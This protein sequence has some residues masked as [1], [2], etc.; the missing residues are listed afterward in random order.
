LA[1][2]PWDELVEPLA[3]KKTPTYLEFNVLEFAVERLFCKTNDD[4]VFFFIVVCRLFYPLLNDANH[5]CHFF[6]PRRLMELHRI[7]MEPFSRANY[8]RAADCQ[9]VLRQ[10]SL[11]L[12]LHVP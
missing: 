1:K 11:P 8:G 12:P 4:L 10:G 2:S 5:A 9:L 3:L 6:V 7:C